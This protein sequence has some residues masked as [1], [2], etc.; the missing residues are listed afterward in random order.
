MHGST[1]IYLFVTPMAIAMAMYLV[2][3]QIGAARLS[4][5]ARCALAG[6]WM[7]L[8]GGTRHAAGWL[9]CGRRRDATAGSPTCRC[10]TAPTRR[11][12]ARTCGR[13]GVILAAVG[14]LV[15][16]ACVLATIVRRRAPGMSVLRMPV[17]TWTALVSVLMVVGAFPV[18]VAGDGR[19]STSNA[20]GGHIFTG[21]AGAIDY[22]DMFW[23][24]GHPVV[25]VMFF[26]YLGAA[27]EA[28]AVNAHK[29]WFGYKAFVASMMAFAAL[30]MSVWSHHMFVTG[31]VT[32]QYFAFTSTALL[33]PGRDR[34]LRHDRHADRRL[35]R[36]AHL[37]AVRAGVLHPVPDRRAQR[38]LHRLAGARLPGLRHPTSSSRT[39]TTRCS[40]AASSASSPAS[41]TGSRRSPAPSCA[42]VSGSSS[43]V[44]LAI[45]TNM[46]FFPMFFLGERGHAAADRPEYPTAP[47]LGHAQPDSRRSAPG[48]SRSAWPRSWS[49]CSS[50]CAGA[51]PRAT[52]PGSAT[53]SSGPPPRRRRRS[54]SSAPLPPITLLRAAARPAPRGDRPRARARRGAGGLMRGG[55]IPILAWGTILLRAVP[56]GNWVWDDRTVERPGGHGGGSHRLLLRSRAVGWR[57]ASRSG[58]D[59]LSRG[60]SPSRSRRPAW[61]PWGSACRSGCALFGLAWAKFLL[62]FGIA[63]IVISLGRLALELRAERAPAGGRRERGGTV[64]SAPSLPSLLVSHWTF[65]PVGGSMPA[66]AVAALYLLGVAARRRSVAGAR[67][68]PRSWPASASVLV[69][70]QSGLDA[71]DDRMLSDHMVQHLLLLARGAAA[72]AR[73]AAGHPGAARAAAVAVAALGAG[74]RPGPA[75]HR[76]GRVA[77]LFTAVVLLTHLPS[78]YD[79]TL[80][81]PALHY[82]EHAAVPRRRACHVLAAARRRPGSPSPAGRPRRSSSTCIVG[83]DA[84][85][86]DRRLPEPSR[87]PRLSG[88]R[89]AGSRA[90]H[91]GAGRPGAGRR[92]HVGARRLRSWSRSGCGRR[93]RRWW[94]RSGVRWRATRRADASLAPHGAERDA[95]PA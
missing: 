16:A 48:S 54:T 10:R 93:W 80:R 49:T 47:G 51:S 53:R 71:Y 43:C 27:A 63:L 92:D 20:H 89:P 95:V 28:I 8:C 19:C 34:V 13:S 11:G 87:D 59:R 32:N 45:G 90:G 77:G 26:P 60:P 65:E 76:S 72:A 73:R 15:M 1:M 52:T 30:S 33:V 79:A 4:R 74:A 5:A 70:L 3:L 67:G 7:W 66:G 57:G 78:F 62:Y 21:F 56:I 69:A 24:F 83:D 35:D 9:T 55:A 75:L 37:D 42:S 25:Y 2:P 38:D 31:G 23:F 82:A 86:A 84:D 91:L 17:F 22:Q 46:T 50:R 58:A 6:F 40:P 18:L 61:P 14:M 68:R 81:H 94:P 39:S 88:L 29:R 85:G 64:M 36:A 44:L 12:S 41:T